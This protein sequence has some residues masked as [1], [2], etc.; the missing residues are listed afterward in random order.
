MLTGVFDRLIKYFLPKALTG[1]SCSIPISCVLPVP[2]SFILPPQLPDVTTI[3]LSLDEKT[4]VPKELLFPI[5]DLLK[6]KLSPSF[7]VIVLLLA[8]PVGVYQA[9]VELSTTL[10]PSSKDITLI[11]S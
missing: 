10:L 7:N 2:A 6:I 11:K 5:H 9:L 3:S 4:L 1:T 8:K